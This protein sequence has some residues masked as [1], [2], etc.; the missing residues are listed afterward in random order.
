MQR[1]GEPVPT[2][3]WSLLTQELTRSNSASVRRVYK[4]VCALPKEEQKQA[5]CELI[6]AM[7]DLARSPVVIERSKRGGKE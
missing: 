3:I 2:T 1:K 6:A 4:Q 5:V 7:L